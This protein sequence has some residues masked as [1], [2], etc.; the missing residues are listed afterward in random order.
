MNDTNQMNP[1]TKNLNGINSIVFDST[2]IYIYGT[3][4]HTIVRIIYSIWSVETFAGSSAYPGLI[5]GP[6]ILSRFNNP[7]G[8]GVDEQNNLYI[9]EYGNSVIRYISTV[10]GQV[11]TIAGI[12][13]VFTDYLHFYKVLF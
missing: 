10:D 11:Y 5:D 2:V 13:S 9:A 1:V 3:C 8:M 4:G 6:L 12:G 7:S